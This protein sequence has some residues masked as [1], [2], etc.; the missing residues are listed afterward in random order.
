LSI[1]HSFVCALRVCSLVDDDMN[2]KPVVL[3]VRDSTEWKTNDFLTL[4]GEE[5]YDTRDV[6]EGSLSTPMDQREPFGVIGIVF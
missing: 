2:Q 3:I 4:F 5:G 6:N 1:I